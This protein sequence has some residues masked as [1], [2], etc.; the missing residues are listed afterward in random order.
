M[1][2]AGDLRVVGALVKS[3]SKRTVTAFSYSLSFRLYSI[4]RLDRDQP[5]NVDAYAT[6]FA[7]ASM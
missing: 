7:L 3:L 5:D 4:I 1:G 2:E 6:A